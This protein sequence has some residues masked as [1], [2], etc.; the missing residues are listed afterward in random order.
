MRTQIFDASFK[1]FRNKTEAS[2][3]VHIFAY[4]TVRVIV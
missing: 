3:V 4:D 2:L 1:K